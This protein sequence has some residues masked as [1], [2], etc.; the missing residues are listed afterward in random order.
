[1]DETQWDKKEVKH[2]K[3]KHLVRNNLV[4]LVLFVLFVYFAVNG[5]TSLIL[6]G[7]CVLSW[8]TV[9]IT[10]YTLKTGKT[11]GTKI[12]RMM[13]EFDRYDLGQKRWKRRKVI[14][15]VITIVLSVFIT[16]FVFVND[17]N[18]VR[19]DFPIDTFPFIGAWVGYN[20][21]EIHRMSNL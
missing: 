16:V 14:E 20:M 9:A 19:F 18:S 4:M 5:K 15:A 17:F 11:I 2:L 3:K 13:Q 12:S 8:I 7:F 21:G 1:M 6:G 10:L